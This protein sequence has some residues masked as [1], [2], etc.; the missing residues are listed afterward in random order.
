[1]VAA[2][3]AGA[4]EV[5]VA[6]GGSASTDLGA[7]LAM[8]CGVRLLRRDGRSVAEGGASLLELASIDLRTLDP[9]VA[10][11]R[12]VAAVDVGNP[13]VGRRGAARVFAP[14][15]GATPPE[16][17]R[18]DRALA[19]AAAVIE[20]DVG[21]DVRDLEGAGAAGGAAAGLVAFLGARIRRGTDVVFAA[22]GFDAALEMTD[23]VVTGE[24]RFDDTSLGGK[25]AGAVLGRAA[26]AG[27]PVA[28][29]CGDAAMDG[30]GAM[31]RA[32]ADVVGRERALEDPRRSLE[33]VAELVAREAPSLSSG[34]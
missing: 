31:V 13:L 9:R 23:L 17:D 27:V 11:T 18:L 25:V 10:A 7:G 24:G 15:K 5:L 3:R 29:V 28:I 2:A 26:L 16:V 6:L 4:R 8:A 30:A 19:H 12:L 32:L 1:V 21:I 34:A 20:R 33:E 14:Q 22:V